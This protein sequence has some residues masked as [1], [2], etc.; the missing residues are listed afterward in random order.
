MRRCRLRHNGQPLAVTLWLCE[1]FLERATGLLGHGP[2]PDRQL[3]GIAGCRAIHTVGMRYCIDLAFADQRGRVLRCVHGLRPGR[4][5]WVRGAHTVFEMRAGLAAGL[6][7][8]PGSLL[9]IQ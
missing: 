7:I 5:C 6:G 4:L 1:S 9:V 2:L 8:A 3:L